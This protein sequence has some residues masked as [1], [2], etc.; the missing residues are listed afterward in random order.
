MVRIPYCSQP[1]SSANPRFTLRSAKMSGAKF[2][3]SGAAK[4]GRF[5]RIIRAGNV[6]NK[7]FSG[8]YGCF[9]VPKPLLGN[10]LAGEA[11][12]SRDG[13]RPK[14]GLRA[15]MRSQAGAWERGKKFLILML[16]ILFMSLP[17]NDFR[18]TDIRIQIPKDP[19]FINLLFDCLTMDKRISKG[20]RSE[21]RGER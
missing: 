14:P 10:A 6:L 11:P 13:R 21:V 8:N 4:D 3:H 20:K 19:V 15:Q 7:K 5:F 9:L 2:Q 18:Q 16:N 1:E 17:G 12:A